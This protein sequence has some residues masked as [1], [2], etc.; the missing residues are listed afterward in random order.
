MRHTHIL[1]RFLIVIIF[2]FVSFNERA[3]EHIL[4]LADV[5]SVRVLL[6]DDNPPEN[7]R[8]NTVDQTLEFVT[9]SDIIT[10]HPTDGF[11][12]VRMIS[13]QLLL[14]IQNK[15]YLTGHLRVNHQG[16]LT[17][18]FASANQH[19]IYHGD[20]ELSV[21]DRTGKL[22][23]VNQVSLEDYVS[24]V[25]GSEM[26][27]TEFEA[28][29]SQAVA[30]RT[31]ALWNIYHSP[32]QDFDLKDHEQSQVYLGALPSRPDY[33]LAAH[34]TEGEILTWSNR[35]ILSTFSSTC[36][37]STSNNEH[38]WS[39]KALPYLRGTDDHSMCSISPHF[40]WSYSTEINNFKDFIKQR[41]GFTY[42]SIRL[43]HSQQ[44]RIESITIVNGSNQELHFQGNEFRLIF[45][46]LVSEQALKS[47]RFD[48]HK[49]DQTIT[50][51]GNGL[52]HGVGLCQWGAKGFSEAGWKY[53]DILS[54][55]F[56]G[57]NIVA[58]Q[59]ITTNKIALSQ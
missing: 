39:G 34:E 59:D 43:E 7:L 27:F 32:Y 22:H 25:V 46:Q 40:S 9:D 50:F 37:G 18:I 44:E 23:V 31:Y 10:L 24:S 47:T 42:Q 12:F 11:V 1:I 13:N 29:K 4:D 51:V 16:G 52:G 55:Y 41:Y 8:I 15:E 53:R 19:R 48:I 57:T 30:S 17:A 38:V 2:A 36:G 6:F 21:S 5:Q 28:L 35:L 33:R 54:F 14:T 26:N 20:F 58:L 3:N 49:D 45:N 56:S